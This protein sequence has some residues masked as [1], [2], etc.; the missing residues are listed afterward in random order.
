MKNRR[1]ENNKENKEKSKIKNIGWMVPGK[2]EREKGVEIKMKMEIIILVKL[3]ENLEF[4]SV[5]QMGGKWLRLRETWH[6]QVRDVTHLDLLTFLVK[7]FLNSQKHPVQHQQPQPGGVKQ[8]FRQKECLECSLRDG[9]A[10][11][12]VRAALKDALSFSVA[13]W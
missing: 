9:P 6:C 8:K 11:P 4:F 12:L 10:L 1:R 7:C 2:K 13:A 5:Q 3:S